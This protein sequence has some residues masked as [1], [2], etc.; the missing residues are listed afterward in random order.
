MGM[1][2][3]QKSYYLLMRGGMNNQNFILLIPTILHSLSVDILGCRFLFTR[4]QRSLR[5]Y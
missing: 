1:T 5:V 3:V 4:K 2:K